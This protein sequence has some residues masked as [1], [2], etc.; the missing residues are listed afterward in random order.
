[1]IDAR[2]FTRTKDGMGWD[3]M[4]GWM[5]ISSRWDSLEGCVAVYRVYQVP[6]GSMA[7]LQRWPGTCE[8]LEQSG[9]H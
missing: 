5:L 8:L 2:P 3:G 4:D 9:S 6:R 1:M 7:G